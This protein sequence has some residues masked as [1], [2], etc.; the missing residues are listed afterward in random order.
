ML[1]CLSAVSCGEIG[2]ASVGHVYHFRH[3]TETAISLPP[4]NSCPPS[5]TKQMIQSHSLFFYGTLMSPA[6]LYRVIYGLTISPP[7]STLKIRPAILKVLPT[8]SISNPQWTV[9][10]FVE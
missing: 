4:L 5:P 7:S 3:I 6:V 2:S 8:I 1:R 9:V 10:D